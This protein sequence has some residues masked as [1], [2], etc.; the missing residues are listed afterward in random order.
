MGHA[1]TYSKVEYSVGFNRLRGKRSLWPF[2]YHASG[3]PIPAVAQKLQN[4]LDMGIDFETYEDENIDGEDAS[5]PALAP[6][7]ETTKEDVTKFTSKKSKAASKTV[8]L[9]YQFQIMIAQGIPRAEIRKFAD[10]RYWLEY[11][12]NLC[13]QHLSALGARIDWRRYVL[14]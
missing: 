5:G 10:S 12:P 9:K 11:F 2:G 7:S 13:K 8:K 3:M 4:E 6:T 1:F 14:T